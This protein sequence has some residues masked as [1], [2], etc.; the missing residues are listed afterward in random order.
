VATEPRPIVMVDREFY[1]QAIRTVRACERALP[2]GLF[3]EVPLDKHKVAAAVA[4]LSTLSVLA[5]SDSLPPGLGACVPP[6]T[7]D[8]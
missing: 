4:E 2:P 6:L 5:D 3:S 7:D 1:A 8:E